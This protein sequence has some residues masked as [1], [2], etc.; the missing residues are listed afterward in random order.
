MSEPFTHIPSQ[1]CRKDSWC[2]GGSGLAG[3]FRN[4]QRI[5][6]GIRKS[7]VLPAE[8]RP[9]EGSEVDPSVGGHSISTI[10]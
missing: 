2:R 3:V 6:E 1:A 4:I 10:L 5:D 9:L 7:N 8:G